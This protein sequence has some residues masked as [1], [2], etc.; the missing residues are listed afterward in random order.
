MESNF[1]YLFPT[2]EQQVQYFRTRDF[3][4]EPP[5][6]EIEALLQKI[7]AS[8]LGIKAEA[9]SVSAE[10]MPLIGDISKAFALFDAIREVFAEAEIGEDFL[11]LTTIRQMADYLWPRVFCETH[12]DGDEAYFPLMHFQETLYFH[13]K[14]FVQNEPSGL[15]CYIY[16]NARMD[17]DFR[18]DVFDKALNY[19]VRRHPIMRSVIDEEREKPRF[20]V[21]KTVPEVHARHIDVSHL[22][23]S[24]ERAYILQ[25][26]LELNDHRF[27][28]GKWPLFFCEITKFANDR[29]VFA[30][31]IDHMLVDGF[32]YMQVFDELFNTYDRMVL[33]EPWE[34]PEATMTFGDYVRV[35]NLRQRTQ[36]YKNALEFQLGLFKDLPSK[37]LLP[38]KRNPALLKE[39][40]FDTFY[41][42]IRPEIIEGLNAIAAE[43]QIS[44]NALLLAAYFKLMNVW[45]HQD[46]MIINMPVFN[47]EQYFAGARKTVGS[48]IDI[49]PVRLQTHFDEPIVQIARKAEAFTR[50]L[51]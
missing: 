38:T 48:F 7:V 30:M 45:C 37:A 16:L 20:K 3:S 21:F 13:R 4:I 36:E 27:D 34:L 46:D 39:V 6:N 49:F 1:C 29:Y 17:G 44:L 28:L 10:L 14:G 19:V 18:P 2:V 40:Y 25:R 42:E 15:S 32:S 5:Q 8:S 51:L 47:R 23:P 24:E 43:E 33:G 35:E 41:Q 11:R 50:K 22:P 12:A 9:V 31:N 26:G